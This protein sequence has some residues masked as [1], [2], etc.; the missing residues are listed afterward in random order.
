MAEYFKQN[1]GI[2]LLV[3]SLVAV[4]C[5]VEKNTNLSR[6]YH[7]V[8]SNY[9]IYFN[10]SEAYK[11]GVERIKD[12]YKDDYSTILPVFE[13]SD[14]NAARS[15]NS[16]MTRAIEKASK[17]ISLHSITAKPELDNNDPLSEEE[18]EFYDR[19][20]FNDW[21]DDSY[22]LMGKAQ[23]HKHEFTDARITL[24]HN[25]RETHDERMKKESTIWLARANTET[26]NYAEA[27]RL[28]SEMKPATLDE[29]LKA[30]YYLTLADIRIR[31]QQYNTAIEPMQS[32]FENIKGKKD[33]NRYAYILAR[34][35]EETG[36]SAKATEYYKK[37]L[38]LNPPYEM[39]FNARIS[40]AGVFDVESG[41]VKDIRKEL[42]KLLRD[43][44]NK[45]YLDQIYFAHGNLSM[46]EGNIDEAIEY[47]RKSAAS[48]TS[49]NNQKGRSFLKL[50]EHYYEKPDYRLSQMYYDSAVTFL[51]TDYPGYDEYNK[52]SLNLNELTSYLDVVSRQDSL[53][54][55]A[56]LSPSQRDNI[57][58]DIIRKIEQEERRAE[59]DGGQRYNMGRFYENQRRFRDNI[60][61]SGKWYFY[62]QAALTFGRTEFRNRWGNRELQD[63]W[64]RMNKST[65]GAIRITTDPAQGQ[66]D[67]ST[68]PENDA[69]SKE[70]YLK[71]LPLTDS[72]I[73]ISDSKIAE[74]LFRA[75]V[76]YHDKFND[77]EKATAS[78]TS[79]ISRFPGHYRLPEALY[80]LHNINRERD[81]GLAKMYKERLIRNYPESEYAKILS[82][83]GYIEAKKKEA[84]RAM[85]I[86]EEAYNAYEQNHNETA[87]R[88]CN[89][90]MEEYPGS[91]LVPKFMLL[92]TYAMAKSIDEK[93]LKQELVKI[94]DKYPGTEEA[95][96]AGGMIA[97][98]NEKVPELKKE[99]EIQKAT[100]IYDTL[101]TP[102][103]RFVMVVKNS[104]RDINRLTF[105][106]I[107]YNIDNY[108][109][110]N[111]NTAGELVNN[112]YITVTVGAFE[113]PGTA[114]EYY[115]RFSPGE[116]ISKQDDEII[117]FIISNSNY[118]NF[119]S[120]KNPDR[121]YLFFRENY[122]R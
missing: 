85:R 5:S 96:R 54:Y 66:A 3:I 14:E 47:Y 115:K 64:R 59:M 21:V 30:A 103:Y 91:E 86:Y 56:S 7:E 94:T 65:T 18:K 61:A 71:N 1:T 76:V 100:Q 45:E 52:I 48:S 44:K 80:N 95:E 9:N 32:A 42:N 24:M 93:T 108:T 2:V 46:R 50:A 98:L 114:M 70:Y 122:L 81:P 90:G 84:D 17:L 107:N 27:K 82:D 77:I 36:N 73:E 22:L 37:V 63:N 69:R 113:E 19:K 34:L 53:Q 15:G 38:G 33:K 41:N 51:E 8:T 97:Y 79:F 12:S 29:E 49:N 23:I 74:A 92:R 78:Y 16:S 25:I 111:Y 6:F 28:L 60:N 75:S 116:I 101:K 67:E 109:N 39:E 121:Y 88:I 43:D 105:D 89:R 57:I 118:R 11:N 13:Y 119:T 40:Q 58:N 87:I 26:G 117:T 83:P 68:V 102:P 62:N 4:S 110:E 104:E 55:V 20:E 72:L 112:E 120:D 10:G 35:Y 31:Q 106:V 99:E